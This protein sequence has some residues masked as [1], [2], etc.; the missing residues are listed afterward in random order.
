MVNSSPDVALRSDQRRQIEDWLNAYGTPQQVV[1]RCRIVLAAAQGS[2]DAGIAYTLN[3][4]RHTVA[5]WRRRFVEKGLEG[6]WEIAPGR[7]RKPIYGPDKIKEIIDASLQ[8][9]PK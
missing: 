5:L 3:V 1:L 7:G 4:N 2:T 6:L 9:K 8:T